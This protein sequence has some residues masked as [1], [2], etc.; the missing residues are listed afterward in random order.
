VQADPGSP[1]DLEIPDVTAALDER[2]LKSPGLALKHSSEAV[3]TMGRL[4]AENFSAARGLFSQFDW[5]ACERIREIET[6]LDKLEDKISAYLLKLSGRELSAEDSRK[7]SQLLYIISEFER[8]GDYSINLVE[9]LES[10]QREQNSFSPRACRE[11]EAVLDAVQEIVGMSVDCFAQQDA[12]ASADIE[13]LEEVID[14]MVET[15]KTRH[16]ER[17][18]RGECTVGAAFPFV[19]ALA[20]L[21][22][23]SDHCSN[24][25]MYII[26]HSK[27][28]ENFDRHQYIEYLHQ[29]G[30]ARYQ[31]L[32]KQYQEKYLE[33]VRIDQAE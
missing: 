9:I 7:V 21:E 4:A 24:T 17:M 2:F 32:F 33:Q 13:P 10:M 25:A 23:I 22:R 30:D 8:I 11:I 28:Y 5:K 18:R 26:A 12:D 16:I 29:N 31:S 15:L 20:N 14:V 19:E 1:D 6:V 3:V 27:A